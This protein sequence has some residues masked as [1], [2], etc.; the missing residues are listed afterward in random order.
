M[1]EGEKKGAGRA[2]REGSGGVMIG[3]AALCF[4]VLHVR[5]DLVAGEENGERSLSCN[6]SYMGMSLW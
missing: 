5:V 3:P 4:L 2:K 6:T 1:G